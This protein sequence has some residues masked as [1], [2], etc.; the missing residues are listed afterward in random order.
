[1]VLAEL[2]LPFVIVAA[3]FYD[4]FEHFQAKV[5]PKLIE[6]SG[7]FFVELFNIPDRCFE[8]MKVGALLSTEPTR[9]EI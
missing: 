8:V 2:L 1:M 5:L 9:L 7:P 3:M 6:K 4:T